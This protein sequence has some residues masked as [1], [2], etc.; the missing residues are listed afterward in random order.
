MIP[1]R[2]KNKA[3]RR[4]TLRERRR[5]KP[6]ASKR[7]PSGIGV[8]PVYKKCIKCG[9]NTTNHHIFCNSCH[10]KNKKEVK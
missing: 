9:K 4:K 6:F 3:K 7:H 5:H 10:K 8:V 1:K 2:L